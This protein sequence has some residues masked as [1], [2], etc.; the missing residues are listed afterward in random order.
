MLQ[1]I[2]SS[3]DQQG[4]T[5]GLRRLQGGSLQGA[6][7]LLVG[8][9]PDC[10]CAAQQRLRHAAHY[11]RQS[12]NQASTDAQLPTSYQSSSRLPIL[13][14]CTM[15]RR[16]RLLSRPPCKGWGKHGFQQRV[17]GRWA[18]RGATAARGHRQGRLPAVKLCL[19]DLHAACQAEM[20]APQAHMRACAPAGLFSQFRECVQASSNKRCSKH[21]HSNK[22]PCLLTRVHKRVK[23]HVGDGARPVRRHIPNQVCPGVKGHAGGA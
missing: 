11:Y 5:V 12:S 21:Q 15:S 13:T 18:H 19:L 23:A 2:G 17:W 7:A 22:L 3:A 4:G 8:S 14:T 1:Q 20:H 6:G 16:V 10:S 9:R